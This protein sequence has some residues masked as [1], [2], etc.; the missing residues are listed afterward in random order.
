MKLSP[1]VLDL[2]VFLVAFIMQCEKT[3]ADKEAVVGV[4][5]II[6]QMQ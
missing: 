6:L 3:I 1:H 2:P 4:Q 5:H